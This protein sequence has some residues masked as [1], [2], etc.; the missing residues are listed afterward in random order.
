MLDS[1]HTLYSKNEVK[2]HISRTHHTVLVNFTSY[3]VFALMHMTHTKM[4]AYIQ[5]N[6]E[7]CSDCFS[8]PFSLMIVNDIFLYKTQLWKHGFNIILTQFHKSSTINF[9][10]ILLEETKGIGDTKVS[11]TERHPNA[12]PP[13]PRIRR[14]TQY[15]VSS[16]LG[17]GTATNL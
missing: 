12:T 4:H 5:P 14:G 13:W 6:D 16:S 1:N 11:N 17:E 8:I 7:M 3:W 9:V 15:R 2:A 10:F